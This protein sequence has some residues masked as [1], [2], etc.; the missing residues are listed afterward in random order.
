M[1]ERVHNPTAVRLL[2]ADSVI[3]TITLTQAINPY[4]PKS[5]QIFA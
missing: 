3:Q 1:N 2:C 5:M 4:P